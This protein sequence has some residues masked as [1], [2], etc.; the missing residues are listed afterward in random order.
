MK[1]D[2]TRIILAYS[3]IGIQLAITILVFLYGGFLLDEHFNSSPVFV[4]I[5]TIIGMGAGFYNL[6]KSLSELDRLLKKSQLGDNNNSSGSKR[7]KWM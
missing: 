2:I 4:V 1:R 7:R 6:M 3:T 5:G